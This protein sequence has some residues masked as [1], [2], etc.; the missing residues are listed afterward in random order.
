M[1]PRDRLSSCW[2]NEGEDQSIEKQ[3]YLSLREVDKFNLL[4]STFG[5]QQSIFYRNE[6]PSSAHTL[7]KIRFWKPFL[8]LKRFRDLQR[9]RSPFLVS[10]NTIQIF[11]NVSW[12]LVSGVSKI[13]L[14]LR[15]R[16]KRQK[17]P[18]KV[19]MVEPKVFMS[20]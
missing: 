10:Y 1:W 8:M 20:R 3:T 7:K 14:L 4:V 18:E 13:L 5:F 19:R 12:M 9:I 17:C 11:K 6:I 2:R 16:P 15:R